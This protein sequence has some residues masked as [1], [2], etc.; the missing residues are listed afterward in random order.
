MDKDI[1]MRMKNMVLA[2]TAEIG[3]FMANRLG[4]SPKDTGIIVDPLVIVQDGVPNADNIYVV[5][6]LPDEVVSESV[7][8]MLTA[9][10]VSGFNIANIKYL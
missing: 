10:E 4:M 5:Y 2:E 1:E 6:S 3:S 7:M 9:L 8:H